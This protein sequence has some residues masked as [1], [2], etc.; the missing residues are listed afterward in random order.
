[1]SGCATIKMC[2]I[3]ARVLA[4]DLRNIYKERPEGM[5]LM[6][7]EKLAK[8]YTEFWQRNNASELKE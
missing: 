1:M 7:L 6:F 4:G 3:E 8:A 2:E 5:T